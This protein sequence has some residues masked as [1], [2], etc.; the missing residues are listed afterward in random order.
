MAPE[1]PRFVVAV[2][3]HKTTGTGALALSTAKGLALEGAEVL[4]VVEKE[5]SLARRASEEGIEITWPIWRLPLV[6]RRGD[7]V[8]THRSRDH[9]L[10]LF[11]LGTGAVRI[12]VWSELE[13]PKG[14]SRVLCNLSNLVV[15]PWHSLEGKVRR[16]GTVHGGVEVDKFTGHHPNPR[17]N[18]PRIGMVSRL[19]LGRGHHRLLN[20]SAALQVEHELL[21]VGDGE[22]S[23][24]ITSLAKGLGISHRLELVRNR[25]ADYPGLLSSLDLLVYLSAGSDATCRTVFEAMACGVPVV[26]SEIGDMR[27]L[28]E[29]CG[30]VENEDLPSTILPFLTSPRFRRIHGCRGRERAS[31]S[32]GVRERAKRILHL[33]EGLG[34]EGD[35]GDKG[36]SVLQVISRKGCDSGGGLQALQL[37]AALRSKEVET[38]FSAREEGSCS[39]R[40][41]ELGVPFEAIPMRSEWDLISLVALMRLVLKKGARVIHVHK[42]LA[43]SLA[44][45][46]AWLLPSTPAVV[47]NRGVSFPLEPW[48]LWRYKSPLTRATVAVSHS[49]AEGLIAQGVSPEKVKVIYGSVDLHRFSRKRGAGLREELGIPEDAF[50]VGFIAAMRP[51]KNH[52]GFAEAM[53]PLMARNP[54]IHCLFAGGEKPKVRRAVKR[55]LEEAGLKGRF[56]LLGYRNDVERVIAAC[57]LTVNLSSQGEGMPGVLRESM[58]CEVPVLATPVAGNP[59]VVLNGHTGVVLDPSG[60]GLEDALKRFK[61]SPRL[62]KAAGKK[63]RRFMERAFSVDHRIEKMLRLYRGTLDGTK[64]RK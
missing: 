32:L 42:G 48:S 41:R 20:A 2:N 9:L 28:L 47:A 24:E 22:L 45:G 17:G 18:R 12:R 58:A 40:S 19:K 46:A 64:G 55:T 57:D 62:V 38:T 26:A 16:G 6:L 51:W 49:V 3:N 52:R 50:L 11:S 54:N 35:E 4:M 63:G 15:L 31:R 56:H 59:E 7:V 34:K 36:L 29:G 10:S 44:L 1:G 13:A 30:A 25:V 5:G 60:K 53:A 23:E 21:L 8:I 14:P 37:A 33:V 61:G 43:H 39:K 27:Y